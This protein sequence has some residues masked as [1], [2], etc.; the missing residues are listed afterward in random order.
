MLDPNTPAGLAGFMLIVN[1][2]VCP[3]CFMRYPKGTEVCK[4]CGTAL[5]KE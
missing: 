4:V 2:I 3:K 5:P 1:P